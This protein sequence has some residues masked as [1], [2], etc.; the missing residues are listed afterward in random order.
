MQVACAGALL[1]ALAAIALAAGCSGRVVQLGPDGGGGSGGSGG[2]WS[3][4]GGLPCVTPD[5]VRLCGGTQNQCGWVGNDQCPGGGCLRPYDSQLDGPAKAGICYSDL[6]DNGSRPC[7]GCKDGEVCLQRKQGEYICV[8]ESVCADLWTM[9]VRGVCRYADLGAYDG[10]ALQ[11]LSSCPG[12]PG[13]GTPDFCGGSCT[14]SCYGSPCSGRSPDHPQGSCFISQ[15]LCVLGS[16]GYTQ[17]CPD[18]LPPDYC[19][20]FHHKS[21]DMSVARQYGQCLGTDSCLALARKLPGGFDCFDAAGHL[22]K[23]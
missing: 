16:T 13:T 23:P 5:G 22:V 19:G 18:T 20:V 12:S 1:A 6:A 14:Q 15:T 4:G 8:P 10:R 9:G 11:T 17:R 21:A 7:W 2:G 3:G